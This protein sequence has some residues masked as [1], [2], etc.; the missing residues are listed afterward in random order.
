LIDTP[1]SHGGY[2][3][4]TGTFLNDG[5]MF[6]TDLRYEGSIFQRV[7]RNL[8]TP[9]ISIYYRYKNK[10]EFKH[11]IQIRWLFI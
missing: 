11:L 1:G 9:N 3:G 6:S 7:K 10:S 5:G 8:P 4:F 2:A